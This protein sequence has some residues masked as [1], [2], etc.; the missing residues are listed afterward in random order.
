MPLY[1]YLCQDCGQVSEVLLLSSKDVPQCGS[2]GGSKLEKLISA[3]SSL[4]GASSGRFPEACE[5]SHCGVSP[6]EAGCAGPGSCCGR[7]Q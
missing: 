1:E 5:T 2:C 4:S 6:G 3:H 7:N